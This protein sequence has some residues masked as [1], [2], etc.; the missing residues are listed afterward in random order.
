MEHTRKVVLFIAVSLDGYIAKTDGSL[1]WLFAVEGEG[2]NGYTEF[3]DTIDTMISGRATYEHVL[4]MM[5][6]E[7]PHYDK[8]NI[9]LTSS[10]KGEDPKI[11]F[12]NEDVASIVKKLR[13]EPGKNIWVVGGSK[14][15]EAFMSENLI[16]EYIITVTPV[17]LGE[18]IPLFTKFPQEIK[19][20]LTNSRTYG[21]FVQSTYV[22]AE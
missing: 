14:V 8:H 17:L 7:Y 6:N 20:K 22:R 10:G 21:Q 16:D 12:S 15:I 11:S 18:G 1:E 9:V 4:Q 3:Y 13:R 19:L 2:S 5:N